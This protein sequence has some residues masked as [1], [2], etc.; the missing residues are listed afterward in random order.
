[1]SG[2]PLLDISDPSR[3]FVRGLVS[4][5]LSIDDGGRG[6]GV[7]A[8]ASST[9]SAY[10]LETGVTTP[11]PG[12]GQYPIKLENLVQAG[13]VVDIGYPGLM[14]AMSVQAASVAHATQTK[15]APLTSKERAAVISG[16]SWDG[17][18]D[19]PEA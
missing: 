19:D 4:S 12:G 6:T 5:D 1:M 9:L 13:F 10:K 14:H 16:K 11:V 7:A 8:F 17:T 3:P 15:G 18:T 2:G